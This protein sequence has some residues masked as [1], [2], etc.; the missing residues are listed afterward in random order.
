MEGVKKRRRT[1]EKGY[2][3]KVNKKVN[4]QRKRK[5]EKKHKGESRYRKI[6]NGK[7][8]EQKKKRKRDEL[9]GE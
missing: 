7:V 4:G 6:T 9:P 3:E 5:S 2:K 8:K 1:A